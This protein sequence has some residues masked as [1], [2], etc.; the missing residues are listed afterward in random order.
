[1]CPNSLCLCSL[2]GS[3]GLHSGTLER[4]YGS[5]KASSSAHSFPLVPAGPKPTFRDNQKSII[6]FDRSAVQ[7]LK[8]RKQRQ[9]SWLQCRERNKEPLGLVVSLLQRSPSFFAMLFTAVAVGQYS[10]LRYQMQI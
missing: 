9:F 1:M 6:G 10:F 2:A 4:S 7:H 3:G 8:E 5:D